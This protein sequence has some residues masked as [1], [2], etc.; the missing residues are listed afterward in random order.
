MSGFYEKFMEFVGVSQLIEI[1]EKLSYQNEIKSDT[2]SEK[3]YR[4]KREYSNDPV[5]I[6]K[7]V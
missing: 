4:K 1:N 3:R 5:K 2:M 7:R 6:K